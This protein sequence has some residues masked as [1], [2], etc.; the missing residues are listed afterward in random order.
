[1]GT[2]PGGLLDRPAFFD[3]YLSAR[4]GDV[5]RVRRFGFTIL[6]LLMVVS[7][8]AIGAGFVLFA[9]GNIRETASSSVTLAEMGAVKTALLRFRR[10]TGAFP[11]P[12]NPADFSDLYEQGS[13]SA[14]RIDVGR[15]WRGPYLTRR[16][17]GLVDL[18][19]DLANSGVGSPAVITGTAHT[20]VR[21]VAD[22][23]VTWPIASGTSYQRCADG[24]ADNDCLLDWRTQPGDARHERWGRPYLL[25][26]LDQP[27]RARLMG[28]GPNGR[29]ES[30][31]CAGIDCTECTAGGDDLVV[32][33]AY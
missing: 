19:D 6:E 20:E 22:P 17:E 14:W 27:T 4:R 10:D 7:I 2:V 26:E 30:E 29:Y 18:G 15:G 25:F 31:N 28:M 12:A 33:L 24:A 13:Q 5:V 16:G 8:L 32:C 11:V 9:E 1:L 23:F 21:S 3:G